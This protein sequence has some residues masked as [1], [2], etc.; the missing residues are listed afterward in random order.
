MLF[1]SLAQ[2]IK[3]VVGYEGNIVN[4][5]SKPDGTPRKLLD[6]SKLSALGWHYTTALREG[7]EKVYKEYASF[8]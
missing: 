5:I 3:E 4:D 8:H 6:I 7:L 2:M 1:R